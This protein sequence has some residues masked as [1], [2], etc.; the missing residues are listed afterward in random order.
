MKQKLVSLY[1]TIGG[2][3]N[4]DVRTNGRSGDRERVTGKGNMQ[5]TREEPEQPYRA[6]FDVC[7]IQEP[8]TPQEEQNRGTSCAMHTLLMCIRYVLFRSSYTGNSE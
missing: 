7:E 4:G 5:A 2:S 6:H 8:V 1:K 3:S